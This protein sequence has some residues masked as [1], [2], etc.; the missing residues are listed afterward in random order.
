MVDRIP[1]GNELLDPQKLIQKADIQPMMNVADLGCGGSG[2]FTLQ[3]AK[4]VGDKG[5]VYAVDI[6]K[7]VLASVVSKARMQGINNVKT[8]WSNLEILGATKIPNGSLDRAM[9]I[10]TLFQ[11]K[12]HKEMLH[13]A[14]RMIKR[15]GMLL[16]VDWKPR[17]APFGPLEKD[18]VAPERIKAIAKDLEFQLLESFE[19]GPY[20]YGFIF[21]KPSP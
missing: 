16:V 15:E 9:F 7:S 8:V 10:N 13:E 20:H 12:K 5:V 21:T 19:A 17:G 2:I 3:A 11:S 14:K 6:L 4:K 1:G 18:R